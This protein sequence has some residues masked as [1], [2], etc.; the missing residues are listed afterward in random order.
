MPRYRVIEVD[1]HGASHTEEFDAPD[2]RSALKRIKDEV[3]GLKFELWR[4]SQLLHRGV[5]RRR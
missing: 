1:R 3:R 2:D 4:E 5:P